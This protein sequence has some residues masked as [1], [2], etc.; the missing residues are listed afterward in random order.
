[1]FSAAENDN[2][3]WASTV[4][5]IFS[6]C[7]I[8]LCMR[9]TISTYMLCGFIPVISKRSFTFARTRTPTRQHAHV[10][11]H[12]YALTRVHTFFECRIQILRTL[13]SENYGWYKNSNIFRGAWNF[14][15]YSKNNS[16]QHTFKIVCLYQREFRKS[17]KIHM[18]RKKR[19]FWF[20]KF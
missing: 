11:K 14:L 1:M 7:G 3:N 2:I 19:L 18:K 20:F 12:T 5:N 10:H 8:W 15:L 9:A 13:F 4:K 17:C 16:Q 6:F